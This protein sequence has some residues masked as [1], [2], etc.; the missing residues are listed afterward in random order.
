MS[1][2]AF[3]EWQVVCEALRIGKQSIILRKG[4]IAEGKQGFEFKHSLF[5]LYPTLFHQ[6]HEL[7]NWNDGKALEGHD[8]Q[9][10]SIQTVCKVIHAC[11]LTDWEKVL[12]L[13]P[14]H[15]WKEE[16]IHERFEYNNARA[17]HLALVRSYNLNRPIQLNYDKSYGGCKSWIELKE[18][19]C[20][21]D[22]TP[23]V[24]DHNFDTLHR[25]LKN[26]YE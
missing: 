11:V 26:I 1:K 8:K 22:S 15:I 16:V 3:K 10:V 18:D 13:S 4:G 5:S 20:Q 23:A 9:D 14:Y 24:D 17:I 2:I 7:T 21:Q 19:P 25:D 6:Q 12:A